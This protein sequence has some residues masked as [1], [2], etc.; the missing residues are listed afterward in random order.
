MSPC[1]DRWG[2]QAA[3]TLLCQGS[4]LDVFIRCAIEGRL[5]ELD[6]TGDSDAHQQDESSQNHGD[7]AGGWRRWRPRGDRSRELDEHGPSEKCVGEETRT[8]EFSGAK[9]NPTSSWAWN[10]ATKNK[11]IRI[12]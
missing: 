3:R 11:E 5:S 2:W 10:N 1:G 4:T 6:A 8:L 12:R 9:E 7:A